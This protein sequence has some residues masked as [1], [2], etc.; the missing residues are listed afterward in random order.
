M[1]NEYLIALIGVGGTVIGTIV[2]ARLTYIGERRAKRYQAMRDLAEVRPLLWA[3]S[4]DLKTL[5]KI[6]HQVDVSLLEAGA[7]ED[8]RGALRLMALECWHYDSYYRKLGRH[9][10]QVPLLAAF[11]SVHRRLLQDLGSGYFQGHFGKRKRQT[12]ALIQHVSTVLD[13]TIKND[14]GAVKLIKFRVGRNLDGVGVDLL[15][16]PSRPE[17]ASEQQVIT[18]EMAEESEPD[19]EGS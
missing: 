9:G 8:L 1:A 2:G 4:S 11:D 19:D 14:E 16:H 12:D 7:R 6:L 18:D 3:S 13:D 17:G 5:R 15:W 10:I